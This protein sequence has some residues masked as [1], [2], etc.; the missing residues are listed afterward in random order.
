MSAVLSKMILPML[1]F[2]NKMHVK[3]EKVTQVKMKD[4]SLFSCSPSA[5]LSF[6][7]MKYT[8]MGFSLRH[9]ALTLRNSV[10]PTSQGHGP[11]IATKPLN[12]TNQM[13]KSWYHLDTSHNWSCPNIKLLSENTP[14]SRVYVRTVKLLHSN[15]FSFYE[16]LAMEPKKL[17]LS[18]YT[19]RND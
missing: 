18:V 16:A 4:F 13:A 3:L 17:W 15:M 12:V 10:E 6:F 9:F 7:W 8:R 1:W 19:G 2:P 14:S 11:F 5:P